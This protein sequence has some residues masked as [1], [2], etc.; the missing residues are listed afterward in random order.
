MKCILGCGALLGLIGGA[1]AQNLPQNL[2]PIGPPLV[3]SIVFGAAGE[4]PQVAA[5]YT[6]SSSSLPSASSLP[7]DSSLPDAPDAMPADTGQT[8]GQ[9]ASSGRQASPSTGPGQTKRILG[10]VP[11]FRSVSA[12]VTLPPQSTKD[13]F[14]TGLEDGFDYSAVIF[15]GI[16]AGIAQAQDSY[17]AFRQ[18]AAGYGRY[19]WHTFADQAD[20]NLWVESILPAALHE[21]S[22]YYTLGQGGFL[23]RSEYS[24]TRVLVTR[25][26]GGGETANVS[27]ILGAGTSSAIS[28]AYYP[29]Q[30]RTWTKVGQR[31]LTNVIL[32]GG[33]LYFK[34]FW[35]DINRK[36]SHHA[37]GQ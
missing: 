14:T 35:P 25:K 26:D 17:P 20:E 22:R 11:N 12:G 21:D 31:W 19:F 13:K 27:E 15:A 34:E 33:T 29:G 36:F 4:T 7:D 8:N 24:L 32:D 3:P 18:G 28:A 6:A 30:Y 10:I 2:P 16:Q 37:E 23:K 9:P 1:Q 5:S